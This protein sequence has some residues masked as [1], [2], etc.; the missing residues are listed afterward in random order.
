DGP[1]EVTLRSPPPLDEELRVDR[2]SDGRVIVR[3]GD[4]LVAEARPVD[5]PLEAPAPV[6]FADAQAAS[7]AYPSP[8]EHYYPD[9]FVCGPARPPGDGLR[10]FAGAMA[11]REVAAAPFVVDDASLCDD[12]G[13]VRSE[14]VWAALDC[15][16]WFGVAC[17]HTVPTNV[18]I[19]RLA[20]RV[21]RRPRAGER[22]VCVGWFIG[23]EGRKIH[24]GSAIYAGDELC[25]VGRA[26]WLVLR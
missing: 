8:T 15:P 10:V 25:A 23:R 9:C 21:E 2:E 14:I 17:F 13:A 20:G 26:V 18:L 4:R 1:A 5:L 11:G 24:A 3:A 7:R 19:G 22:C 12:A 6:G 16:S